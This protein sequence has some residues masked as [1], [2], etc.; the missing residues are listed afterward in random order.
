MIIKAYSKINLYLEVFELKEDGYHDILTLFQSVNYYDKL[1][2]EFS[3]KEHFSSDKSFSFPWEKNIIKKTIDIF[4]KETGINNFNLN[5][6]LEKLLPE[7]GGI[8][9]G[10]ADSAA[11]LNFLSEKFGISDKDTAE[12]AVKCGSDVPFL[13]KGGTAV[14]EKRGEKLTFLEPLDINLFRI[15]F[16]GINVSTKNMYNEIDK[17]RKQLKHYGNPYKLY[18]GILNKDR[19]KTEENL[20]NIFEQVVFPL[21]PK[22]REVKESNIKEGK[23]SLMSGSGSS[24]FNFK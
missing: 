10:S 7:G 12:I 8:G 19:K 24:V 6:Y 2:I 13:L 4:K 9:G 18:E 17:N 11:V 16:L 22:I 5:I 3:E 14:A 15:N 20:F 1:K 23:F 21:Y